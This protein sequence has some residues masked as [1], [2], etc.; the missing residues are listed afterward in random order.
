[1]CKRLISCY[2][3]NCNGVEVQFFGIIAGGGVLSCDVDIFYGFCIDLQTSAQWFYFPH[4]LAEC[5]P[6]RAHF[7]SG[8]LSSTIVTRR[9]DGFN[10][11]NELVPVC[12]VFA[13]NIFQF[14]E[15]YYRHFIA[16]ATLH[17]VLEC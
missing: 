7:V 5:T 6:G 11:I 4:F 16:T 14:P 17:G 10:R 2:S 9:R 3:A 13:L 12:A 1:M 15:L 8:M